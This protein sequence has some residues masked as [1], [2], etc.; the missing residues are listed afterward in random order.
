MASWKG[1]VKFMKKFSFGGLA[2]GGAIALS[3]ALVVN[4]E[5]PAFAVQTVIFDVQKNPEVNQPTF[6]F[7]ESGVTLNVSNPSGT[8]SGFTTLN[9][10]SSGLCAFADIGTTAS[11][12]NY[13][14]DGT[15]GNPGVD[16]KFNGF[17]LTFDK[18]GQLNSVLASLLSAV[19]SP[20]ITF[21]AGT[22]TQTFT[23]F[24]QGQTLTFASPLSLAAG[25]SVFVTS[26]GTG[27][28]ANGSGAFRIN[29]INYT[30]VPGPLGYLGI[31]AAFGYSRKL[32]AKLPK[33]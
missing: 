30:E 28:G 16:E 5:A 31:A 3:S 24:T 33:H 27:T 18:P 19:S 1:L 15:A 10:S 4:S 13:G 8:S 25:E 32:K 17:T 2:C 9:S 14:P 26:S 29:S 22:Q 7:T 11:R 21:T 23:N 6:S 12:C 20:S